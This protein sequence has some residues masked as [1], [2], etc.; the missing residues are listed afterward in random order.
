MCLPQFTQVSIRV[1][2]TEWI[3]FCLR[4]GELVDPDSSP[5]FSLPRNPARHPLAFREEAAR[6]TA[7]ATGLV[8]GGERYVVGDIVS[9]DE[10]SATSGTSSTSFK[11][12]RPIA[13]I[14]EFFRYPCTS[15]M[16]SCMFKYA[17]LIYVI[18]SERIAE[19]AQAFAFSLC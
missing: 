12:E 2:T 6:P 15:M 8:G 19:A 18:L 1:V 7:A 17:L 3:A 11:Q 9:Y 13:R 5:T 4:L 16:K 10:R 14:V